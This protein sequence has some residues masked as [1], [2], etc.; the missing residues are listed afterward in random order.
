MSTIVCPACDSSI[1]VDEDALSLANR[2][3][4]EECEALLEVAN[5]DPLEIEWVLEKAEADDESEED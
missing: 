3:R 5:E 1:E 2:F 4:C